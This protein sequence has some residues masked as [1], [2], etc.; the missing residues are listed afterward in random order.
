[1]NRAQRIK[2]LQVQ[3]LVHRLELAEDLQKIKTLKRKPFTIVKAIFEISSKQILNKKLLALLP[4]LNGLNSESKLYKNIRRFLIVL[5]AG[6]VFDAL[7]RRPS[8]SAVEGDC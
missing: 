2:L 8:S 4:L 3:G 1:M 7:I 6:A 5:G